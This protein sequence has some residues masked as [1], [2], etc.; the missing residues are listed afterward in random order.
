MTQEIPRMKTKE[1]VID[2][3][4]AILEDMNTYLPDEWQRNSA[5]ARVRQAIDY[6]ESED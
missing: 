6:L 3:L 5:A 2:G 4:N 1:A